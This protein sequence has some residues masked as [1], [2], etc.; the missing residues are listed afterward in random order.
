M[1]TRIQVVITNTTMVNYQNT[2]DPNTI[3]G[4]PKWTHPVKSEYK[5]NTQHPLPWDFMPLLRELLGHPTD[6]EV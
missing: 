1:N 4:K 5:T 6:F 3:T 2:L